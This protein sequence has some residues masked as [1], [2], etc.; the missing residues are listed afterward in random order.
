[1]MMMLLSLFS[2]LSLASAQIG[3]STWSTPFD[4][5]MLDG[6]NILK[7]TGGQGPY[8][9]RDSY[10]IS[11]DTPEGCEVDQM[12]MMMRHGERYP[13]MVQTTVYMESLDKLFQYMNEYGK[14]S[15]PLEFFNT[16]QNFL[17]NEGLSGQETFSGPYSGLL[18][19]F[20]RGNEYRE[21]YGHLWDSKSVV[22]IFAAGDERVIVTARQFGQGFFG[23]NYST[24]AALNIIPE[25]G[26]VPIRLLLHALLRPHQFL[27]LRLHCFLFFATLWLA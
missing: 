7:L 25:V 8:I 22:P 2:L 9:N 5:K 14:L 26:E 1:M 20:T 10:G 11:V 4:Q 12:I 17:A 15:G 19:A 16:W 21:R 27:T 6:Y 24:N 18:T 13:A 23:Y 3:M